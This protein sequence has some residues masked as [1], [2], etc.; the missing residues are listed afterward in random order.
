M[1]PI[2]INSYRRNLRSHVFFIIALALAITVCSLGLSGIR[3]MAS[4]W[5]YPF[6]QDA[7]GHIVIRNETEGQDRKEFVTT[8]LSLSRIEEIVTTVFP[9]AELTATVEVPSLIWFPYDRKSVDDLLV[10][11]GGGL[12]TW[13]L[14]PPPQDGTTLSPGNVNQQVFTLR[15]N[16]LENS[17]D[18]VEIP[19]HIATYMKQGDQEAWQLVGAPEQLLTLIGTTS[20]PSYPGLWGH[21]AV[22][23][24]LSGLPSDRVNRV[25]IALPGLA[26][27]L[28]ERVQQL[29]ERLAKELPGVELVTVDDYALQQEPSLVGLYDVATRY[30]PILIG[31]AL[32]LVAATALALVQSRRRELALFR[33]IGMSQRQVHFLFAFECIASALLALIIALLLLVMGV[34][35][36]LRAGALPMM[37]FITT[38]ATAIGVSLVIAGIAVPRSLPSTLRNSSNS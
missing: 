25:G 30:T 14:L 34:D 13:Y 33:I 29:R 5:R 32:A 7:G 1:W 23:Q 21:L 11:R 19:V 16:H 35:T 9:E 17:P 18:P 15:G 3:L 10:G 36:L 20:Y 28:D 27:Q 31:L 37:P 38:I 26:V 4:L 24:R 2:I 12:D 22:V 6:M 8:L